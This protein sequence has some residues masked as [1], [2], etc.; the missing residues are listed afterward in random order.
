MH[1]YT[2]AT[3]GELLAHDNEIIR[4]NSMSILKQL[5]KNTVHPTRH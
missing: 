5:T 4:R 2:R 1:D 3:L